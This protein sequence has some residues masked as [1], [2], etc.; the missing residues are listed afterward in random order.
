MPL[1]GSPRGQAQRPRQSAR[2]AMLSGFAHLVE[3][4]NRFIR[5]RAA[6]G[7]DEAYARKR[8]QREAHEAQ[9]RARAAS[10]RAAGASAR[11]AEAPGQVHRPGRV[12]GGRLVAAD[13]AGRWRRW[14]LNR[15][16]CAVTTP[17]RAHG[18]WPST[19]AA[20]GQRAHV[21]RADAVGAG[22]SGADASGVDASGAGASGAGAA[23]A[24]G[25]S[26]G[27]CRVGSARGARCGRP[28][29]KRRPPSEVGAWRVAGEYT[30]RTFRGRGGGAGPPVRAACRRRDDGRARRR[31][32]R[33]RSAA[34]QAR[35]RRASAGAAGR[36]ARRRSARGAARPRLRAPGRAVEAFH[37]RQGAGFYKPRGTWW[38]SLRSPF[39]WRRGRGA[40]PVL[41]E[42][43]AEAG[44]PSS[45]LKAAAA[46]TTGVRA[47]AVDV[48]PAPL[49]SRRNGRRSSA[50]R[51]HASPPRPAT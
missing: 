17:R 27:L 28:P 7:G 26:V 25:A 1:P 48:S 5:G 33:R 19:R 36:L 12:P 41:L 22:A 6:R 42:S 50:C 31:R 45:I 38:P 29:P 43:A 46:A 8:R 35:R 16:F 34:T 51:A 18:A 37:R 47:V 10:A 21:C 24:P 39:T 14:C 3:L 32:A 40:N 2:A 11:A 20:A 49:R 4:Q 9:E 23:G 44:A 15:A 13:A 30:R